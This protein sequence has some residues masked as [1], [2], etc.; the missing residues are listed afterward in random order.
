MQSIFLGRKNPYN[1]EPSYTFWSPWI[2]QKPR[3]DIVF[4]TEY[5]KVRAFNVEAESDLK[6]I[7]IHEDDLIEMMRFSQ[8]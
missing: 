6:T 8:V 7:S 2:G 5:K 4:N 3:G 1:V